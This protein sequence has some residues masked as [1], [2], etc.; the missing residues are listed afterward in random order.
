MTDPTAPASEIEALARKIARDICVE[1]RLSPERYEASGGEHPIIDVIV[2]HVQPALSALQRRVEEAEARAVAAEADKVC[3]LLHAERIAAQAEELRVARDEL[4][5]ALISLR[6]CEDKFNVF[7]HNTAPY[8][9]LVPDDKTFMSEMRDYARN[10]A[11]RTQAT[12]AR[13][14]SKQ[15]GSDV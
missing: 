15:G 13:L 12:L 8:P 3:C 10:A 11:D 7:F 4:K 1:Y 5:R 6:E 14:S 2:R 9:R